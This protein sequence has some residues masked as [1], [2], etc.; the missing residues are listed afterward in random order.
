MTAV[1]S[2]GT[3]FILKAGY[4]TDIEIDTHSGRSRSLCHRFAFYL[5]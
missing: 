3:F 1:S 4:L 2:A 5:C